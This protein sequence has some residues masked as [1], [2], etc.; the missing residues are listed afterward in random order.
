M[1]YGC[2]SVQ[3]PSSLSGDTGSS[4]R[5]CWPVYHAHSGRV[6]HPE[7][8]L[9]CHQVQLRSSYCQDNC[10]KCLLQLLLKLSMALL[11]RPLFHPRLPRE[12]LQVEG[13]ESDIIRGQCRTTEL[14]HSFKAL[15]Q[16]PSILIFFLSPRLKH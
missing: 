1:S 15:R 6:G 10:R 16:S 9:Q 2:F 7:L 4:G 14:R 12:F 13:E 8:L 5:V 3:V 11:F